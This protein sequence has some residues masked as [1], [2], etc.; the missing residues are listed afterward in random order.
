MVLLAS[1]HATEEEAF[2]SD[3]A[4][5]L[6]EAAG[7]V[8]SAAGN[9]GSYHAFGFKVGDKTGSAPDPAAETLDPTCVRHGQ[10]A[11][12]DRTRGLPLSAGLQK[13]ANIERCMS[14][15][16]FLRTWTERHAKGQI[17]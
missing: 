14:A 12:N 8:A 11:F 17:A 15:R 10:R 6:L 5:Q 1:L 13:R 7:G 16:N 2:D 3:K 4:V 9:L